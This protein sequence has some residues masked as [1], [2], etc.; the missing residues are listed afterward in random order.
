MQIK[1]KTQFRSSSV[2]FYFFF[3]SYL[4]RNYFANFPP[5]KIRRKL[6]CGAVA[7]LAPDL[8]FRVQMNL[9]GFGKG[10]RKLPAFRCVPISPNAR[11]VPVDPLQP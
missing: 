11:F 3:L 1:K 4:F 2:F 5:K 6:V 9:L 7:D 10:R 8:Q